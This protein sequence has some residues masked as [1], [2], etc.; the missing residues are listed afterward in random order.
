MPLH[1]VCRHTLTCF[2]GYAEHK[3]E[4]CVRR[5]GLTH[6]EASPRRSALE[7]GSLVPL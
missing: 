1:V 6:A 5:D 4:D 2:G 3:V 7:C